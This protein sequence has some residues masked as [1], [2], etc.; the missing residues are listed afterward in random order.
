MNSKI[1]YIL[2]LVFIVPSCAF[3]KQKITNGDPLKRSPFDC[4]DRLILEKQLAY[5]QMVQDQTVHFEPN[6]SDIPLPLDTIRLTLPIESDLA[7]GVDGDQNSQFMYRSKLEQSI[8][9]D[10]FNQQM[11][12]FGWQNEG[13]AHGFEDIFIFSKLYKKAVISIRPCITRA[14]KT[15]IVIAL[16]NNQSDALKHRPNL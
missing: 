15:V 6:L 10:F 1:L 4:D 5:K 14:S 16:I 3:K 8:L 9:I 11:E 2:V 7:K 12:V 13:E